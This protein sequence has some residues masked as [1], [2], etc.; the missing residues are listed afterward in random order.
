MLFDRFCKLKCVIR[1]IAEADIA[2][3]HGQSSMQNAAY[4]H[5]VFDKSCSVA[6]LSGGRADDERAAKSGK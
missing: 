3:I 4:A 5:E 2:D 1:G 6:S